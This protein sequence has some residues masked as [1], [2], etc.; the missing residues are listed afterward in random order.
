MLFFNIS[1]GVQGH[2]SYVLKT[3]IDNELAQAPR[4]QQQ[5]K[6]SFCFVAT[7]RSETNVGEGEGVREPT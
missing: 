1:C 5:K 6:F 2:T 4:P 3:G 7:K